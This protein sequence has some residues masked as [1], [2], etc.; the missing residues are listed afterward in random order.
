MTNGVEPLRARAD[1]KLYAADITMD[2]YLAVLRSLQ[3]TDNNACPA[4]GNLHWDVHRDG[5]LEDAAEKPVLLA[6]PS[7]RNDELKQLF[8]FTSCSRC[9]YMRH[10]RSES[11][12]QLASKLS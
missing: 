6:A 8:F 5:S 11:I 4:C 3:P 10:Y 2:Q 7:F 1:G 9:G 12:A